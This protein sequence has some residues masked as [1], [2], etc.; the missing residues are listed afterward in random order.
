MDIK[1]IYRNEQR[2]PSRFLIDWMLHDR[3]TYDCSYCPPPNKRGSDNW[4]S[5]PIVL[6]FS[7]HI[8]QYIRSIDSKIDIHC[9]F[10]GGEPTVWKGFL[11]VLNLLSEKGWKV[12]VNTNGSRS[13]AWWEE[14][15][16]KFDR[17][18]MSYHSEHV[19]DDEFIEKA[20]I[21]SQY[22][23]THVNIMMNTNS[24]YFERCLNF[25]QRLDQESDRVAITYQKIQHNFGAQVIQVPVYS[26][27][28]KEILNNLTNKFVDMHHYYGVFPDD[29]YFYKDSSGESH[30]LNGSQVIKT[31]SANFQG[32]K[33][34]V[35]LES[36]FIDSLGYVK[37][38]TCRVDG[39]LGNITQPEKILWPTGPVICPYDWCGCISDILNSKEKIQ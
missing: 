18:F 21:C 36:I 34:N 23:P 8:E 25:G 37:K 26:K 7:N 13:I 28:Q 14:N 6:N 11:D 2:S 9:L 16:K 24:K 22:T 19:N 20:R 3:C 33:C 5:V 17:I 12:K 38:G 15:A 10:T 39:I 32:W 27:E 30:K 4:L 1:K 29:N 35:G 31:N